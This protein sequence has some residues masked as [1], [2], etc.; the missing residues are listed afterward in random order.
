[1]ISLHDWTVKKIGTTR[2]KCNLLTFC[3]RKLEFRRRERLVRD[4]FV[5]IIR[6]LNP[7]VCNVCG[8]IFLARLSCDGEQHELRNVQSCIKDCH[9]AHG[10]ASVTQ[11][12]Y[13][14]TDPM[15]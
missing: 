6:C 9:G 10:D 14:D 8:I 11:N 1:M 5:G 4:S 2:R 12:L 15:E 7:E 3:D 13:R